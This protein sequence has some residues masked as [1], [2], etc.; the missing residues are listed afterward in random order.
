MFIHADK[1]IRR[2]GKRGGGSLVE[3]AITLS[4]LVTLTFGMIEF[5][6]FFYVKNSF[7]NAAREGARAAIVPGAQN[8]DVTTAV[9]NALTSCHYPNNSYTVT[10]TDTSNGALTVS[11]ASSG[12]AIQVNVSATWGTIG[13][14]FR[15][16]N[17][18][19][20]GKTVSSYCVMR[21]E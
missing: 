20:S 4:L 12:T 10:V 13:A 3:M 14:G 19:S 2:R 5:G 7:S 9:T 6:Y 8:S 18:I 1:S 16:M 21:K 11:S 17:L 15:P